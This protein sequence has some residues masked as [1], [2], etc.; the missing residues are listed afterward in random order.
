MLHL[1][2]IEDR[3]LSE[4]KAYGE[5]HYTVCN[6]DELYPDKHKEGYC[7][8]VK[9][10]NEENNIMLNTLGFVSLTSVDFINGHAKVSI[11]MEDWHNKAIAGQIIKKITNF[12][13]N[14]LRLQK[15]WTE[16]YENNHIKL[17]YEDIGFIAEGVRKQQKYINGKYIDTIVLSILDK[18]SSE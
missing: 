17:I 7:F 9:T 6:A 8:V 2:Q 12:A 18:E 11:L 10:T 5:K 3:D 15:V 13:I 16:V 1:M 14:E 4:L